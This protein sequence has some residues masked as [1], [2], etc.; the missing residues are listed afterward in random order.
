MTHV[1]EFRTDDCVFETNAT[2]HF[3]INVQ[4]RLIFRFVICPF[5]ADS[6]ESSSKESAQT[7]SVRAPHMSKEL[8]CNKEW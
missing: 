7:Y 2:P 3:R 5:W 6:L 1:L 4:L 8:S